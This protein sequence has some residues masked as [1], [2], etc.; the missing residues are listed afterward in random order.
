MRKYESQPGQNLDAIAKA[1]SD[2]A[3]DTGKPVQTEFNGTILEAQPNQSTEQ[4]RIAFRTAMGLPEND[5]PFHPQT[6]SDALARWDK[7]ES[8]FTI[9]MGGLGPGYEQAIQ[10]LVFEII[11]DYKAEEL[12]AEGSDKLKEWFKSFGDST[13]SRIDQRMGGYSGA[14]VGAA[15][16]VAYRA[17]RDGWE[18]MLKIVPDERKIQVSNSFPVLKPA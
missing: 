13:V 15:K 17:L 8:V 12:P 3:I 14:M 4:T 5:P 1:M 9:E 11:R 7:G 10:I 16:Q 18:K 2:I 6:A